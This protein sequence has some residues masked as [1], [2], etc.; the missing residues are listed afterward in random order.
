MHAAVIF[1]EKAL[2]PRKLWHLPRATVTRLSSNRFTPNAHPWDETKLHN[3]SPF[4]QFFVK[5]ITD[6]EP[7]RSTANN[8]STSRSVTLWTR[9]KCGTPWLIRRSGISSNTTLYQHFTKL[10]QTLS[11]TQM[12]RQMEPYEHFH[13]CQL[14]LHGCLLWI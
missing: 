5:S 9:A 1:A 6:I 2:Q 14:G 4:E 10:F 7:F 13:T 8:H 12:A 11:E 3:Q